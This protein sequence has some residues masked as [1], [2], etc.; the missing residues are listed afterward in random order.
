MEM[1]VPETFGKPNIFFTV[2]RIKIF[3]SKITIVSRNLHQDALG[4]RLS[5]FFVL[6]FV[7]ERNQEF[8]MVRELTNDNG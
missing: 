2:S 4:H 3:G 7:D 1:L 6:F 5:I 8:K